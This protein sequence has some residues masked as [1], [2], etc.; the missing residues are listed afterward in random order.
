M[1]S[2]TRAISEGAMMLA[3]I[4]ML[5]IVN[6]QFAGTFELIMFLLS[7]PV[8]IYTV[9][10]G[11]KMGMTLSVSASLMSFMFATPT[12]I[13][14][15]ISA[16]VIG[17]IYA[18]G[19]L[20]TWKNRWLLCA[21]VLGNI[22][23]TIITVLMMGAIF[24]YNIEEEMAMFKAVMPDVNG[25]D[26][27]HFITMI[28]FLSYLMMAILQAIITHILSIETLRRLKIKTIGMKNVFDLQ[29]PKWSAIFIV[30]AYVAYF[31]S[32]SF[33]TNQML[34]DTTMVLYCFAFII[35]VVDGYLTIICYLRVNKKSVSKGMVLATMF[36]CVIPV[37]S[38]IIS[39]LGVFDIW[40]QY[41]SK[42]KGGVL[43]EIH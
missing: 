11:M 25:L 27:T 8:I 10:Y 12:S 28:I 32:T 30:L 16:I 33:M 42:M 7:V 35:S 23:V 37:I 39:L 9:K 20:H 26:M 36:A 41:R 38:N 2:K 29:F 43:N 4:G 40:E 5:L 13:F 21:S 19:V 34:I 24:G 31:L 6:R 17:L 1:K 3:I 22:M 15:L 18:Y 14:Y